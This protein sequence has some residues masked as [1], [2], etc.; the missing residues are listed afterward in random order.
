VALACSWATIFV[1]IAY[2]T[3]LWAQADWVAFGG[4]LEACVALGTCNLPVFIPAIVGLF[5]G[6]AE[7]YE[8]RM[9]HGAPTID[10][11]PPSGAVR[12]E[13][14]HEQGK[15]SMDRKKDVEAGNLLS[16]PK[17]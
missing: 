5:G 1:A 7:K 9:D 10:H 14:T 8:D 6:D 12:L 17:N 16:S 11:A 15:P 4:A 13:L 2:T 3:M